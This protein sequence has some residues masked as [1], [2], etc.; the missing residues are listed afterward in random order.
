MACRQRGGNFIK[1]KIN[2]VK[3]QIRNKI[4]RKIRN[5]IGATISKNKKLRTGITIASHA[6][7]LANTGVLGKRV[8]RYANNALL[9]S[10][11]GFAK[12]QIGSGFKGTMYNRGKRKKQKGIQQKNFRYSKK[13]M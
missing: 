1:R 13:V 5:K 9:N 6:Q 4:E 8:K 3:K 7:R 2:R 10:A 12:S 11:L